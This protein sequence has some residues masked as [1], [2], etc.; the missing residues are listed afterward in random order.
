MVTADFKSIYNMIET[1]QGLEVLRQLL[2]KLQE[3]GKLQPDF[4]I[5][6]SGEDTALVM[7]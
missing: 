4:D 5:D 2:E 7:R 3:E 6:M 1:E